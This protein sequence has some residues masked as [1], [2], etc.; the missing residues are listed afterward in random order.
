MRD[1][2]DRLGKGSGL[3][4]PKAERVEGLFALAVVEEGGADQGR[5]VRCW[6]FSS[7]AGRGRGRPPG[8]GPPRRVVYAGSE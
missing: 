4:R 7:R 6:L 1:V 2:I 8:T 5:E 3:R